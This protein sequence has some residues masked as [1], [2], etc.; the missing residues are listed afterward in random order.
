MWAAEGANSVLRERQ[1]VVRGEGQVSIRDGLIMGLMQ[2][3]SLIPGFSLGATSRPACW[4]DSTGS[5]PPGC[6]SS[7]PFRR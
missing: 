3:F 7:W 2:S 6:H 1:T 5:R 4:T